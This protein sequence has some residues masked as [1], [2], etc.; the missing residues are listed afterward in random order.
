[1][2]YKFR[3]DASHKSVQNVTKHRIR[4]NNLEVFNSKTSKWWSVNAY[5]R[6]NHV[7]IGDWRYELD[8]NSYYCPY[9]HNARASCSC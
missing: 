3:G 2:I 4:A 9:C 6:S 7:D 8:E 1:M 5:L